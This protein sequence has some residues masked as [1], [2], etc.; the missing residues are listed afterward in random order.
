MRV[1]CIDDNNLL[2]LKCNYLTMFTAAA[3]RAL[4]DYNLLISR[5]Q[6]DWKF[7]FK[8]LLILNCDYLRQFF[9]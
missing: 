9:D 7:L 4:S 8:I 5:L 3:L 2:S 1:F 6:I